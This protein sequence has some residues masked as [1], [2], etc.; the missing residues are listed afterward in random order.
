MFRPIYL[1]LDYSIKYLLPPIDYK[2]QITLPR[3]A[4]I[5]LFYLVKQIHKVIMKKF[6]ARIIIHNTWLLKLLQLLFEPI[7]HFYREIAGK[8]KTSQ[9]TFFLLKSAAKLRQNHYCFNHLASFSS[10]FLLNASLRLRNKHFNGVYGD[11][12]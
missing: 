3:I 1:H 11:C 9:T 2:Y 6:Q 10:F 7:R 5:K 12:S 4:G 8:Q